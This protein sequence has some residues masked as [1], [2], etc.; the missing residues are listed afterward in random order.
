VTETNTSRELHALLDAAVD[1]IIIID[2]LG[3]IHSFN[4][5]AERLFGFTSDEVVGSNV[6]LLMTKADEQAHD[7]FLARYTATR[8]P[9]I[10]GKGRDVAVRRK[11]GTTFPAHLSV[12]VIAGEEPPR[13]VGFIH[14]VTH[15]RRMEAESH[16]LQ[17][18]LTHVS[19]LATVGEMASGIAHE[20][21]Q[22]LAAMAT[23]AHACDRLLGLPEPD[24]EE[25]R[26]ALRLIADQAVRA[27]D[28]IRRMRALARSEESARVPVNVNTLIDELATL[29]N[30]D[31]KAH[32]V[33]F[34]QDLAPGLPEISANGAQVQQV[35]VNLVRNALEALSAERTAADRAEVVV[36]TRPT[37]DGGVEIS[38]IDNG[39]GVPESIKDRLFDPFCT[40]KAA[41]TGLGLAISRSIIAAHHGTLDY[42]P[43]LPTGARF[44][45]RLAPAPTDPT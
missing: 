12:G 25:V 41:G 34:R 15:S 22:P 42:E 23:Y 33:Q 2:H 21:N 39:P 31:A 26:S 35:V 24:I 13:F 9:H 16:R 43:N 3:V 8:V 36:A 1:G 37:R 32:G 10:I 14:D 44:N 27:G 5:A 28:I 38:I 45:V 6:S 29:I 7:A 40:T 20:L 18:R 4:R 30:S 11:D 17:D 19:R